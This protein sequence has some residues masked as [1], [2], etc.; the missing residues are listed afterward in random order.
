MRRSVSSTASSHL[1]L[2]SSGSENTS[3]TAPKSAPMAA[4]N[5]TI[6]SL[7][8]STRPYTCCWNA[9]ESVIIGPSKSR[10]L[11]MPSSRN[12]CLSAL[13]QMM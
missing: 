10:A 1:L 5:L 12:R 6:S 3:R 2:E 13:F 8:T 11:W 9:P 7:L 4:W